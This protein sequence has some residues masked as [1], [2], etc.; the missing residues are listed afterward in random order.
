MAR[1]AGVA[2]ANRTAGAV[3]R[4]RS[5]GPTRTAPRSIGSRETLNPSPALRERMAAG[6]S[7]R[8][9][10]DLSSGRH[11][12]PPCYARHRLPR[13]GI[14]NNARAGSGGLGVSAFGL[15]RDVRVVAGRLLLRR[16][17]HLEARLA[18]PFA[19]QLVL[20]AESEAPEPLGLDLDLVAVH[21]RIEPAMVGARGDDVARLR[22]GDRGHPIA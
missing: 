4:R 13:C 8:S 6:I 11:P 21:E 12:H 9:G 14:G 10:E 3:A 2:G 18:L 19:L 15:R 17:M 5:P 16:L 22:G 1:G 7:P 20:D